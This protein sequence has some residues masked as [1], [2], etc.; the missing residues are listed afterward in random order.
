MLIAG[1]ATLVPAGRIAKLLLDDS[2]QVIVV[3]LSLSND[4]VTLSI[5]QGVFGF[6]DFQ[7]E[8]STFCCLG[9]VLAC[10]ASEA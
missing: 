4:E 9:S 7:D 10:M 1:E 5:L 3:P 8:G 2:F 6:T